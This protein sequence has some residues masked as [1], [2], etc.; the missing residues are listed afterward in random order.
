MIPIKCEQE[1]CLTVAT[2]DQHRHG[3][4]QPSTSTPFNSNN[5]DSLTNLTIQPDQRS[6]V[7]ALVFPTHYEEAS[8]QPSISWYEGNY[9]HNNYNYDEDS[10][11]SLY[12]NDIYPSTCD[13]NNITL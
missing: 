4:E 3:L 1:Q 7:G 5:I 11:L 12:N 9:I 6:T 13:D 2:D 8:L 10:I